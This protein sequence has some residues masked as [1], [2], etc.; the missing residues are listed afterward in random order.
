MSVFFSRVPSRFLTVVFRLS[1]SSLHAF[2]R[3]SSRSSSRVSSRVSSRREE[4]REGTREKRR[5]ENREVAGL[6]LTAAEEALCAT[7]S[8]PLITQS[9]STLHG[10]RDRGHSQGRPLSRHLLRLMTSRHRAGLVASLLV[11]ASC[12]SPRPDRNPVSDE[13]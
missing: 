8:P 2:S 4:D 10:A 7:A 12:A 13:R 5:E 9:P 6:F 1:H 11:A 3:W